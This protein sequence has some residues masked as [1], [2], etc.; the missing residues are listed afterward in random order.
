[1]ETI[2]LG[3]SD[4]NVSRLGFGCWQLGGHGWQDTDAHAIGLA[5]GLALESGI[6]FFDTADIYG[7]GESESILG[8]TLARHSLRD[9]A[10]IATKFGVRHN[11]KARYY[12][13]SQ[14]WIMEAAEGSLRRLKRDAIDLY[15]LHWHDGKRPL[16]DVFADLERLRADGKIRWYGI[17]NIDPALMPADLPAGLVSFTCE[18]SLLQRQHEAAIEQL[19]SSQAMSFIAWGS[20]AQGLLSGKY[21]RT[22]TF[23]AGDIR[24]RPESIFAP[25]R[26]DTHEPVLAKLK[27]IAQEQG[28]SMAQTALRW[29]LDGT[30]NSLVLTGIKQAQQL[31]DN[32]G[33]L[34]WHLTPEQLLRL[35]SAM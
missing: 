6:T 1:M 9:T 23:A 11:G 7:L 34:G 35:R 30:P 4:L 15:Q 28:H 26:W 21:S 22:S 20:L 13:N 18:Y 33:A 2:K 16:E 5:I 10:V 19:L 27:T 29:V 3:Q 24:S 31:L 8:N 32:M 14:A 25:A 12:D 17:S